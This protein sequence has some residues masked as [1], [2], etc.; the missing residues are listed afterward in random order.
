MIDKFHAPGGS[1]Q[2]SPKV[3]NN[4]DLFMDYVNSKLSLN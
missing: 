3:Y 1:N 2:P 4:S